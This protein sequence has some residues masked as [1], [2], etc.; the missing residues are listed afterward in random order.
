MLSVKRP[1]SKFT[2][3]GLGHTP[4]VQGLQSLTAAFEDEAGRRILLFVL[5]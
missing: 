1:L 5:G 3:V 2:N 4:E